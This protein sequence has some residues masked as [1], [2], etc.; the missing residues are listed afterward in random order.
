LAENIADWLGRTGRQRDEIARSCRAEV[1]TNWSPA[2]HAAR[3][4][5]AIEKEMVASRHRI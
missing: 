1:E 3:I 2:V 4:L 5:S